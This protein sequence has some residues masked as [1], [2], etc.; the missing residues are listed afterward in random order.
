MEV[1]ARIRQLLAERNWSIY[2]L[3]KES[4]VSQSTLSNMFSRNNSPS[5]ST[6]EEICKAFGI[7]LSQFF[8]EDG[9]PMTLD[10]EQS[11]L[12]ERWARLSKEQ[13]KAFLDLMK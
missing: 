5:I 4:G 8:S 3:S 9:E 10:S 12:L 11:L 7:T 6:L 1:L 2:K 13:R